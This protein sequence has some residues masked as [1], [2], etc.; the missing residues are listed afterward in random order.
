MQPS[1]EIKA[2]LDIVDFIKDYIQLTPAGVNFR[3]R[4][5]F[6]NE[7]SPSFVVSPDKQIW[8]CFGCGKGGDVFK[9]LME[10]ENIEFVEALRIL[11]QKAGVELKRQNPQEVSERVRLLD[12]M[13]ISRRFYHKFLMESP[14]AASAR[15]Y[16]KKRGLTDDGLETW[17]IGF[18]PDTWDGLLKVLKAQGYNEAEIMK[19]GMIIQNEKKRS[20]YDR[21]RSRIMFPISDANGHTVAFSAR[22][23]PEKEAT[24]TMGK[25]INSPQTV[26]YNKSQ[27]L[28]ALD[29]AK[30]AIKQADQVII[31]EGQMDAITAHENGYRNVVA[32]SGT[33]LTKEQI[34]LLKRFTSNFALSFDSDAAGH[35]AADRGIRE[36]MKQDID[37]RVIEVQGGK[38]PDECIRKDRAGWEKAVAEAKH[39]MAYY[40]QRT[41][42]SVDIGR[43]EGKRQ[44]AAKLLPIIADMANPIEKS[45]WLRALADS[46]Q[47]E[48]SVLR[49]ALPKRSQAYPAPTP[50]A[51]APAP[52]QRLAP[53]TREE[54]LSEFFVALILRFPELI[55]TAL[56]NL[57]LEVLGGDSNRTIYKNLIFYYNDYNQTTWNDSSGKSLD[58]S[59][60]GEWFMG[61]SKE[62]PQKFGNGPSGQETD[63]FDQLTGLRELVLLGDKEY[64]ELDYAAAKTELIRLVILLK[65]SF[66]G[67]RLKELE[68]MMARAEHGGDEG[69]SKMLVEEYKL[70]AD[71]YRELLS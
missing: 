3:A 67:T 26:L 19:T 54:Q 30:Q 46:V 41:F 15:E 17:Q 55:A 6:H 2:K 34:T 43:I 51:P 37:I 35:M 13:D 64:F 68:A 65:K 59:G 21:F 28:F 22:V 8:H 62:N 47:V 49:E 70:V 25:Y 18:G 61:N 53:K 9:F 14:A 50:T 10:L 42:A 31:V 71:E 60:F 57:S 4:C 66:L 12:I 24:E 58:L 39:M 1:E 16:L 33:A 29:K 11:A 44:A 48:E 69:A 56:E 7:K 36:A 40:F 23:S 45:Y 32:S 20:W 27:I 52:V 63:I 38:D 5:P